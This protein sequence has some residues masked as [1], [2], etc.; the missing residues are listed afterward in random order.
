MTIYKIYN[1][2]ITQL[3]INPISFKILTNPFGTSYQ[4]LQPLIFYKSSLDWYCFW[5]PMNFFYCYLHL[6]VYF[7]IQFIDSD[8]PISVQFGLSIYLFELSIDI[9]VFYKRFKGSL[10]IIL[11]FRIRLI[12]IFYEFIEK[13]FWNLI[14][15]FTIH[16]I[17]KLR[18]LLRRVVIRRRWEL[19]WILS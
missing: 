15:L 12:I 8:I 14:C 1:K 7:P 9:I 6:I 16:D 19:Y 17:I 3:H 10:F 2:N 11:V 5:Y 18:N 13:T 4:N